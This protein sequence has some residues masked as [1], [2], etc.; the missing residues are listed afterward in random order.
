MPQAWARAVAAR[1]IVVGALLPPLAAQLFTTQTAL[2]H[3]GTA[4]AP[5]GPAVQPRLLGSAPHPL[6]ATGAPQAGTSFGWSMLLRDLDGDGGD[7]LVAAAFQEDIQPDTTLLPDAGAAYV[8][9]GS[10]LQ[11]RG[12]K[13]LAP[14]PQLGA[15]FGRLFL[16]AG[17]PRALGVPHV[18]L[19]APLHDANFGCGQA[20]DVGR[21][22]EFDA[23]AGAGV[24][25]TPPFA[26]AP[27]EMDAGYFGHASAVGDV[28]DDGFD[29]LLVGA[30]AAADDRGRVYV[31]FG[32][33]GYPL[34]WT[35][36]ERAGAGR[37]SFGTSIALADLDGDALGGPDALVVG[38]PER[39]IPGAVGKAYVLR[40]V[41]IGQLARGTVHALPGTAMQTLTDTNSLTQDWFGWVVFALGD[42]GGPGGVLDGYGDIAVHAEGTYQDGTVFVG[43][44]F[45]YFGRPPGGSAAQLVNDHAPVRLQIPPGF[46]PL[47]AERFGRAAVAVDWP[48]THG[49]TLRGLLVGSPD[50]D[51]VVDGHTLKQAGRVFFFAAPLGADSPQAWGHELLEPDPDAPGEW[52]PAPRAGSRFGSWIVAGRLDP[53]A[54]HVQ[55]VIAARERT[56]GGL[57]DVGRVYA[58]GAP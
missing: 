9:S 5:L 31:F 39:L 45:V 50:A 3:P 2:Q 18:F 58:A 19:G 57:P 23:L 35:A 11:Q 47:G 20:A 29:D 21:L 54:P 43:A 36:F 28:D 17:D 10:A 32:G 24:E 7:E 22:Y 14:V 6:A 12:G 27:C 55:L 38:A 52:T 40:T 26:G 15:Q 49:G 44:L 41:E 25:L 53:G 51:L 46:V 34:E 42:V 33:P 56:E 30:P 13:L 1:A 37:E 8:F 16:S 48:A 4:P